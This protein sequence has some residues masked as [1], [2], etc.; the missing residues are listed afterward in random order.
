MHAMEKTVSAVIGT[1]EAAPFRVLPEK[2]PS[3]LVRRHDLTPTAFQ[4]IEV[5]D[6]IFTI[7]G[8]ALIYTSGGTVGPALVVV[9]V[10]AGVCAF[11]DAAG[12]F[13]TALALY[14]RA[15]QMLSKK[16]GGIIDVAEELPHGRALQ[17]WRA[18]VCGSTPRAGS[19]PK[20]PE[21]PVRP[22]VSCPPPIIVT[23]AALTKISPNVLA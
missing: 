5:R 17:S 2:L 8:T 4:N 23:P 13:D 12:G 6:P 14:P 20:N 19:Y 1:V 18:R 3:G 22:S 15:L 11:W 16:D 10:F 9:A 7:A 21:T